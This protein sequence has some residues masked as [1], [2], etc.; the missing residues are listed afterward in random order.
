MKQ[1]HFWGRDPY[2]DRLVE[3]VLRGE[4]TVTCA[5]AAFYYDDP[6]DEPVEPG[7]LVEVIDGRGNRRCVIRIDRVYEI[8]FGG[9]TDEI[10]KGEC[11]GSIE[12]FKACHH[13][14]WDADMAK[15]GQVIDDRTPLVVEHFTLV[16]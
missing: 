10:L 3:Q 7:D 16:K 12:E 9:V 6:E 5:L 4:K 8:P 14:C 15:I 11:I 13:L 2:D 1:C